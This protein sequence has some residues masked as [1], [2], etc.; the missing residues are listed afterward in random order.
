MRPSRSGCSSGLKPALAQLSKLGTMAYMFSASSF[1][2]LCAAFGL[3]GCTAITSRSLVAGWSS[4]PPPLYFG[5]VR[6][7]CAEISHIFESGSSDNPW[8]WMPYSIIDFP[9]SL[10][11]DIL[12]VPY[13][14]YTDCHCTNGMTVG[15][16]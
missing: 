13:D 7:D 6:G 3:T 16:R 11:A 4:P 1:I 10:G 5:G 14:I 8:I 15:L 2:L 9:F 12:F